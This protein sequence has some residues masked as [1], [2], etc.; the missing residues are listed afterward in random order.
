M[1]QL[2]V[3]ALATLLAILLWTR[4]RDTAWLLVIIATILRYGHILFE[5]LEFF[6]IVRLETSIPVLNLI[7]RTSLENFPA[8]FLS[9]ALFIMIRRKT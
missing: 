9:I 3:S 8:I 4:T 6:G 2:I 7:A 1:I 5:A